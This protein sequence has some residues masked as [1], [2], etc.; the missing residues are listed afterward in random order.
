MQ[1][2]STTFVSQGW[3]SSTDIFTAAEVQRARHVVNNRFDLGLGIIHQGA[4]V[5]PAAAH[6][7]PEL[8]WLFA[9]P[10]LVS[11]AK[12][13]LETDDLLFTG[14]SDVHRGFTPGWHKDSGSTVSGDPVR[15][16]FPESINTELFTRPTDIAK[17][18]V[19]L[20]DSTEENCLRVVNGSHMSSSLDPQGYT[21]CTVPAG[22]ALAFDVRITH[23]GAPTIGA[24]RKQRLSA[25]ISF[26]RRDEVARWF[27]M[28]N[29]RRQLTQLD[30]SVEPRVPDQLRSALEAQNVVVFQGGDVVS[31]AGASR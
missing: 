23:S 9:H 18:G 6:L 17:I 7:M 14:H 15:S 8:S 22:G 26:G 29:M 16:Y 5:Q 25:F 4:E 13:A 20:Q 2:P 27:G 11:V 28:T 31:G 21:S 12:A 10:H 19:Y 24:K 3:E 1:R 30:V